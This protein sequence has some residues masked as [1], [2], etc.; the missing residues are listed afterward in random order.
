MHAWSGSTFLAL[1]TCG[2]IGLDY[3]PMGLAQS[4]VS[5]RSSEAHASAEDILFCSVSWEWS[6]LGLLA[7]LPI[8]F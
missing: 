6:A 4:P 2:Q 5:T 1:R 3:K 8:A 7:F